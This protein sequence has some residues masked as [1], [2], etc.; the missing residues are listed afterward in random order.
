MNLSKKS[1]ANQR[2]HK[3]PADGLQV[4]QPIVQCRAI[5]VRHCTMNKVNGITGNGRIGNFIIPEITM[6]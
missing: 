2:S 3:K 4:N 5:T 1:T 6:G